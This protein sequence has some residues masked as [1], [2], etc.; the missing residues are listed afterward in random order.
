LK[1]WAISQRTFS[2]IVQLGEMSDEEFANVV[3]K[4]SSVHAWVNRYKRDRPEPVDTPP[5][6]EVLEGYSSPS[7]PLAHVVEPPRKRE[8]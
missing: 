3:S 2:N 5:L 1:E 4:F 8:E 7:P 6:P